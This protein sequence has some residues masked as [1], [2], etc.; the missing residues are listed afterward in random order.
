M[1]AAE[2]WAPLRAKAQARRDALLVWLADIA[3]AEQR[4][5][6]GLAEVTGIPVNYLRLLYV[7]RRQVRFISEDVTAVF[8]HFLKLPPI[9]VRCAAG[10][11]RLE[12]FYSEANLSNAAWTIPVALDAA[13]LMLVSDGVTAFAGLLAGLDSPPRAQLRHL[14]ADGPRDSSH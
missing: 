13:E 12:D 4:D 3:M 8:A 7:G 1:T 6:V 10:D 11:I 9:V 14:I 5:I 2:R